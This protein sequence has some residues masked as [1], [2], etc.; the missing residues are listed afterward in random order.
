[1][2]G[3]WFWWGT[4][5]KTGN[6]PDDFKNLY[7]YTVTYLRNTKGVHNLLMSYSPNRY[8][9]SSEY[10]QF[11]PGDDY[12]DVFGLDYYYNSPFNPPTSDLQSQ[13]QYM[14]DVAKSHGKMA[15]ITELGIFNNGLMAHHNF[16]IDHVL[17]PL[18]T[19]QRTT[20]VA[21][22]LAWESNCLSQCEPWVPYKGHPAENDFRN[23]Y[24]DPVMIFGSVMTASGPI[25]G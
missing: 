24:N 10:L 25:V 20:N 18:K 21:Y 6:T 12:V 5:Q 7:R 11:Y 13:V 22:I 15:A 8:Q 14:V 4:S 16:W 2:N 17:N 19:G 1:M 23:F 9:Q 3:G